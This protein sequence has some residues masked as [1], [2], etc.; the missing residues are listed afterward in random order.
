[1]NHSLFF[2]L[3][4]VFHKPNVKILSLSFKFRQGF[5]VV[6]QNFP[7]LFH[8]AQIPQKLRQ[9]EQLQE[10][11]EV[12]EVSRAYDLIAELHIQTWDA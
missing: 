10:G 9:R 4:S 6:S 2:L 12:R 1:M 3:G 7:N 8:N 5:I 11:S